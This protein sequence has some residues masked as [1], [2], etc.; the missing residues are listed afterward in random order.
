MKRETSPHSPLK[1]RAITIFYWFCAT[2]HRK[3]FCTVN[4][5]VATFC[6][7][8]QHSSHLANGYESNR[9]LMNHT[10]INHTDHLGIRWH[11]ETVTQILIKWN[12]FI[13]TPFVCSIRTGNKQNMEFSAKEWN[14]NGTSNDLFALR[15]FTAHMQNISRTNKTLQNISMMKIHEWTVCGCKFHSRSDNNV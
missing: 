12:S 15:P 6:C 13:D 5:S 10:Q 1:Y 9:Y 11:A 14:T 7:G 3:H 4:F 8:G 2:I